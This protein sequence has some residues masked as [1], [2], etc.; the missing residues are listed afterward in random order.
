MRGQRQGK[1][2]EFQFCFNRAKVKKLILRE[3]G[4]KLLL[5]QKLYRLKGDCKIYLQSANRLTRLDFGSKSQKVFKELTKNLSIEIIYRM[6]RFIIRGSW[7]SLK[8]KIFKINMV[9]K[10]TTT[11]AFFLN[12][13][14]AICFLIL[15]I[16]SV[17]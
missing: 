4:F 17:T 10:P 1:F 3:Q 6:S 2:T 14:F 9:N 15:D 13:V 8:S 12:Y 11:N 7:H 16:S 5:V